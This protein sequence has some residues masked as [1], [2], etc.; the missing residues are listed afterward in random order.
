MAGPKEPY[1]WDTCIWLAWLINENRP[2]E[3]EMDGVRDF[4]EQIKH[5]QVSIMSSTLVYAEVSHA[6]VPAGVMRI[7]DD[8]MKRPNIRAVAVDKKI[9]LLARDLRDYCTQRPDEY[10]SKTFSAPDAIHL[11]TAIIYRAKEFHTF[12]LRNK[13]GSLGLLPHSGNVAGH[14]LIITK[15]SIDQIGLDLKERD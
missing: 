10:D 12:D 3:G 9:A 5:N 6:D 11:A 2:I 4:V 7:F 14:H 8:V 15:P 1:Y 13:H